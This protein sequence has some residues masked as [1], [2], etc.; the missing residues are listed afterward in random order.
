MSDEI[1][2]PDA[3]VKPLG[4]NHVVFHVRDIE[5]SHAFWVDMLGF[6]QVGELHPR[7]GGRPSMTMRFYSGI[8]DGDVNHHDLALVERDGLAEP[9]EKWS[10]FDGNLAVNHIAVTYPDRES[11][12]QQVKFLQ[13][14]DVRINLRVDHGM[15]HS[16]YINDPNGYGVEVLYELPDDVWKHDIDGALNYAALLAPEDALVDDVE[17]VTD[18][19]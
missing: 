14:K 4:F 11:W 2:T 1:K 8:V 12:L 10:L 16:I 19:G 17:Y 9:P 5:E 13:S 3:A 7:K 15:T 6:T 18:F